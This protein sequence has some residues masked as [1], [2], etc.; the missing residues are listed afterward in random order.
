MKLV[1]I[2]F[3]GNCN[4]QTTQT[5]TSASFHVFLENTGF[6]D[7]PASARQRAREGQR[8]AEFLDLP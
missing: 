5:I 6:P 1:Q 2:F 3:L 7:H 8:M 4:R